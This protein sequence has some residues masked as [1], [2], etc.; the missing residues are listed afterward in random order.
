MRATAIILM[1][2]FHFVWDL[3]HFGY[4]TTDIPNGIFWKELRALI[5]SLF[6]FSVGVSL[7]YSYQGGIS[8]KKL[9]WRIA[10]ISSAALLV[11]LS[12]L[13]TLP[14]HWIYFGVLHFIAVATVLLV[15]L[16]G[17][18]KLA[19]LLS[20]LT[21]TAYI[22]LEIPWNWPFNYIEGYISKHPSDLV[23]PFP[24]LALPLLGIWAAQITR[25][26]RYNQK[27]GKLSIFIRF[28]S[29]N[30]LIIYLTHQ[31]VM[32]LVFYFIS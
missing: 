27:S 13:F 1:V 5:V 25:F 9:S 18:P 3:N 7:V 17:K 11:T 14:E 12:S 30:S 23:T 15:W 16:V 6:L 28:L 10:K 21:F 22:V 29:K 31:P 2:A 32:F 20:M 24:W 26:K 19:L 8:A 4:V